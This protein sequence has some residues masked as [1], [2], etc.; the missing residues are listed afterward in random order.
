MTTLRERLRGL[1]E[2]PSFQIAVAHPLESLLRY[3]AGLAGAGATEMEGFSG[4]LTDHGGPTISDPT[5]WLIWGGDVTYDKQKTAQFACDLMNG[6]YFGPMQSYIAAPYAGKFGGVADGPGMN[7]T[8][9]PG[10]IS[11]YIRGVIAA[12]HLGGR[13]GTDIYALMMP[14]NVVATLNGPPGE[15]GAS[16]TEFCGYHS[17]DENGLLFIVVVDPSCSGCSGDGTAGLDDVTMVLSHEMAETMTNPFGTGWHDD[18]SGAENGDICNRIPIQWGPW[19]VQPYFVNEE[20]APGINDGDD[21][22][23]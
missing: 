5:L 2:F 4:L 16:C 13:G 15:Q 11:A 7:T 9:S 17:P 3:T 1:G 21:T 6:T 22:T 14:P 10:D 20:G 18:A 23:C 8:M 12:N 19:I